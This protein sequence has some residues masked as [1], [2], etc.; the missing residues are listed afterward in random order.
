MCVALF[1]PALYSLLV[2]SK[3]N[4]FFLQTRAACFYFSDTVKFYWTGTLGQLEHQPLFSS[5]SQLSRL[6]SGPW[7]PP[8]TGSQTSVALQ[9]NSGSCISSTP[10]VGR[11]QHCQYILFLP[12]Q[13]S[14][15]KG[16]FA[17]RFPFWSGHHLSV[18]PTS[19]PFAVS[20]SLPKMC[21]SKY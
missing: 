8:W 14:F 15:S 4:A 6:D 19:F 21:N 2:L 16:R 3:L 9:V 20:L 18:L 11:V 12:G 17:A 10:W 7:T 5:L 1:P 13:R